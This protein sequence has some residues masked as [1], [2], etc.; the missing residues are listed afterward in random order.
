MLEYLECKINKKD[1][2]CDSLL[3][4]TNAYEIEI[5]SSSDTIIENL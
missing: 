4:E 3:T 2:S 1:N 5:D